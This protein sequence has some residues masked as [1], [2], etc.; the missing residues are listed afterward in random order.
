MKSIR[1]RILFLF[2]F[3]NSNFSTDFLHGRFYSG[4]DLLSYK[5]GYIE[6]NNNISSK[7]N[8]L[9]I[10]LH[11][12]YKIITNQVDEV[13]YL[14]DHQSIHISSSFYLLLKL[15]SEYDF[16]SHTHSSIEFE[17]LFVNMSKQ[18]YFYQLID[19]Q[20]ILL[21]FHESHLQ[22]L[23]EENKMYFHEKKSYN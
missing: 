11:N 2:Y 21:T 6:K 10:I 22:G 8:S 4:I 12:R 9:Y 16:L 20:W 13:M 3:W 14:I 18:V 19:L 17:Q 1:R 7:S 15:H 5:T 23:V